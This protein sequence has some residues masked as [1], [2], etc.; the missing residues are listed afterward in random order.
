LSLF[1]SLISDKYHSN[2]VSHKDHFV[3]LSHKAKFDAKAKP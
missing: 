2:I 3:K 1:L